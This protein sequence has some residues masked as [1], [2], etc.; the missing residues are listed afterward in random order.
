MGSNPGYLLKYFLIYL[1]YMYHLGL[2]YLGYVTLV[3]PSTFPIGIRLKDYRRRTFPSAIS[4][5]F[6]FCI[7]KNSQNSKFLKM[8]E[9]GYIFHDYIPLEKPSTIS[10][11]IQLKN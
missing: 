4:D 2:Y 1:G 8:S 11:G 10:I 6:F 5:R 9:K 3:K 7:L